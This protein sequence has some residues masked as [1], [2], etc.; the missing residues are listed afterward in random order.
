MDIGSNVRTPNGIGR[1]WIWL[2]YTRGYER[3]SLRLSPPSRLMII[4]GNIVP[5]LG[6]GYRYVLSIGWGRWGLSS[7]QG[8]RPNWDLT[9]K[10]GLCLP[11][12]VKSFAKRNL[13]IRCEILSGATRV[14]SSNGGWIRPSRRELRKC[15]NKTRNKI[16]PRRSGD[17]MSSRRDLG[18]IGN[19][20][21][22]CIIP[23][24][25]G[26]YLTR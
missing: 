19:R 1:T 16:V 18:R 10:R 8:F 14:D 4:L 13:V 20:R 24:R 25:K 23:K 15:Q 2:A 9:S 26:W 5:I 7:N 11:L 17:S 21:I 22:Q 6:Q 12:R 3:A